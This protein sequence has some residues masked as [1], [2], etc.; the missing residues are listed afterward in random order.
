MS[1]G[2]STF[3][4]FSSLA[5]WVA[6]QIYWRIPNWADPLRSS[7]R[8]R[9]GN[10]PRVDA[11]RFV[12]ELFQKVPPARGPYLIHSALGGFELLDQKQEPF[13]K[14]S[15]A[16]MLLGQWKHFAGST[17]TLCMPTHPRYDENPGFMYDK[18]ELVLT[19]DVRRTPSSVG[20]LS[21]LFRRQPDCLR[22]LHPLSS[23]AARGPLAAQ[24]LAANLNE[25]RPL[26]HGIDSPY[27]RICE[28]GGT[29]VGIGLPLVKSMTILHVAEEVRDEDWPVKDFFYARRFR[30][31]DEHGSPRDAIVRERRPEF[32]RSLILSQVRRD[33]RS[34]EI[35]S[36]FSIGGVPCATADARGVLE[37]LADRQRV[38][39]YPYWWP[40]AARFGRPRRCL[41]KSVDSAHCG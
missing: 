38:S 33:L 11:A 7:I 2:S 23:V 3:P 9:R 17:G 28:A 29:V 19:Y 22:S 35:L 27:Y 20:L 1:S 18:S 34:A 5:E 6:R 24:L 15:A 41:P 4:G 31:I 10:P 16:A 14:I 13:S 25:R 37:F 12:E 32:V 40:S 26:P 36:E 30:V 21:E 39:T 8:R